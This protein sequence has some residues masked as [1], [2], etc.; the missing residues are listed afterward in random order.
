MNSFKFETLDLPKSKLK[1]L[2]DG[3]LLLYMKC[4]D[5]N[6]YQNNVCYVDFINVFNCLKTLNKTKEK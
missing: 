4:I 5:N 6:S 3:I 1:I 2:C